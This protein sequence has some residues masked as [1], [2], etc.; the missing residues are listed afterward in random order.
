[1]FTFEKRV[2]LPYGDWSETRKLSECQLEVE[3][4]KTDRSQH[5][6]VGDEEGTFN[7]RSSSQALRGKQRWVDTVTS[8]V[9]ELCSILDI[10]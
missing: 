10:R 8:S 1:M 5:D 4:R 9:P 3:E 2:D 6:D 7:T